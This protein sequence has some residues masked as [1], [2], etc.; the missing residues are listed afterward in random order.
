MEY[1]KDKPSY[2]NHFTNEFFEAG[3]SLKKA[4]QTGLLE[5]VKAALS[6]LQTLTTLLVYAEKDSTDYC[7]KVKTPIEEIQ[8]ILYGVHNFIIFT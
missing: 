4:T 7:E 1:W 8:K 3:D 5:D 2:N 6:S